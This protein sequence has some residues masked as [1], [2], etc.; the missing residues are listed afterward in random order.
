MKQ[1]KS[2]D[3]KITWPRA[4]WGH[5]KKP[6]LIGAFP[7]R[8][9]I[10]FYAMGGQGYLRIREISK[11]RKMLAKPVTIQKLLLRMSSPV[12]NSQPRDKT[13]VRI[14]TVAAM[15]RTTLQP[16]AENTKNSTKT[17]ASPNRSSVISFSS[18]RYR[19]FLPNSIPPAVSF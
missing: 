18:A 2:F 10:L 19:F 3:Y 9:D 14:E 11:H 15:T 8:P 5:N 1:I 16:L 17:R 6:G 7:F 13:E 12:M 4:Q